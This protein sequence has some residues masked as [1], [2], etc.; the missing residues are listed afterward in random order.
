MATEISTCLLERIKTI[1]DEYIFGSANQEKLDKDLKYLTGE[2]QKCAAQLENLDNLILIECYVRIEKLH[3]LLMFE[4]EVNLQIENTFASFSANTMF[5]EEEDIEKTLTNNTNNEIS[6]DS[7]KYL[8]CKRA[9][10]SKEV[11]K[12]L[13][14]WL[15]ENLNNPYPSEREKN[16]LIKMTGLDSTQINNWF[17]NARRRIL[18]YMKSKFVNY[19]E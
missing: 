2:I 19:D 14:N 10:Y 18:P 1:Q 13:K 6:N 17:I 15:K 7:N 9:N 8:K 5:L 11:S 16:D 12:I 3:T 4:S